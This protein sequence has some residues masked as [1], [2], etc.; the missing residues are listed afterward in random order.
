MR[1]NPIQQKSPI[2]EGDISDALSCSSIYYNGLA[3]EGMLHSLDLPEWYPE[4][5]KNTRY[6]F[7]KDHGIS[8]LL[9]DLI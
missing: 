3:L 7:P 2:S 1:R 6:L 9:A 8:V 4:Y 5:L